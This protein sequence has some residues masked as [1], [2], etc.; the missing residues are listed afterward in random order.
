MNNDCMENF[1]PAPKATTRDGVFALEPV[2]RREWPDPSPEMLRSAEFN[3][4]WNCIKNWDISV[5]DAYGGYCGATG[6]HVRA[7]LDALTNPPPPSTTP[8][9]KP[10]S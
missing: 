8:Q 10:R 1:T 9:S 2:K 3:T 5:P 7:I 4:V 6:N